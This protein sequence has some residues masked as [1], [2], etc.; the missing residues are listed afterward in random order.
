MSRLAMA[1]PRHVALNALF[2]DPGRSS[3]TE[4]YLRGLAPA[5][6]AAFPSLE[7][8]VLTTRRGAA[9]LR[10]DGWTDFARIVHFPFDD[11]QRVRRLLAEQA[12][13]GLAV[14]R[15]GAD[16]LHSLASTGPALPGTRSVLTLHDVTFF[17]HRTFGLAT[18]FALQASLRCAIHGADA[19]IAGS[20]AARDE[21]CAVL[22]LDA[23][24][25]TVVPHGPGK[26]PGTPAPAAEVE[27]RLALERRRVVLSVGVV[28]AHKNQRQLVAALP[29]LP[30]DVVLVLAGAHEHAATEIMKLAQGTGVAGRLRTPGYL[31]DDV[32]EALWARA[33][34]AAFAT[35]AEGFGLPVLEAMRRGVP[36]ACSDIPVLREVG[37]DLAHFFALDDPAATARAITEAMADRESGRDGPTYAARFSW[38]AAA[39]G[40]YEAYERALCTSG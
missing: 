24:R 21:A 2:L 27:R 18:T 6:A 28:R 7:L 25:F 26:P 12:A 13:I 23:G 17:T 30:E 33:D 19:L 14:R 37:G 22:G 16:V 9:A 3:G 29:H 31:P 8:S 11:G 20:A 10:R 34:C 1:A 4:T 38:E 40:T 39:Q 35:R 5:I 15:R 32:V 36:V